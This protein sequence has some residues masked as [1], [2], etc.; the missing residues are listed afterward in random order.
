M[1]Q[2]IKQLKKIALHIS[3]YLQIGCL[4]AH[5][6]C[7]YIVAFIGFLVRGNTLPEF[8]IEKIE[9]TETE[10]EKTSHLN[11][12]ISFEILTMT[13][14]RIAEINRYSPI[15]NLIWVIYFYPYSLIVVPYLHILLP[16]N[17]DLE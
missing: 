7:H 17:S 10:E 15:L 3:N 6:S 16:S 13:G 14:V 8:N 1:K 5:E 11:A 2:I 4:L 12:N 9:F